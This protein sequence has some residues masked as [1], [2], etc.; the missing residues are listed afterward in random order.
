MRNRISAMLA[1]WTVSTAEALLADLSGMGIGTPSQ[2][3]LSAARSLFAEILD[4][5]DGPR[6][7]GILLPVGAAPLSDRG[8]D[9]A[10]PSLP[11]NSNRP[12]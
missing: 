8:R 7:N 10:A 6:G 12:V 11:T 1:K 4:N 2:A 3:M 5:D 9:R